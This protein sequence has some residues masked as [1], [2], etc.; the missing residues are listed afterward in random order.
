MQDR[1][2]RCFPFLHGLPFHHNLPD[3]VTE[4]E[5]YPKSIDESHHI[6]YTDPYNNDY[7]A[8]FAAY[9]NDF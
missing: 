5:K 8:L 4:N 3:T 9:P 1:L 2:D 7:Q 6:C